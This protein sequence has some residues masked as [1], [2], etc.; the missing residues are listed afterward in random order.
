MLVRCHGETDNSD[1]RRTA[2]TQ[3]EAKILQEKNL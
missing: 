3:S 2:N 1:V